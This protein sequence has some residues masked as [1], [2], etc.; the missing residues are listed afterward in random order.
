[1]VSVSKGIREPDRLPT[2]VFFYFSLFSIVSFFRDS[3]FC[4]FYLRVLNLEN[5][6]DEC[7]GSVFDEGRSELR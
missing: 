7:L 1:M 5:F 3:R 4:V 6:S 2:F